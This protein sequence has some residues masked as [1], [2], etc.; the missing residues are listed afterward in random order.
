MALGIGWAGILLL[1]PFV[2]WPRKLG[3]FGCLLL[4]LGL[5]ALMG[6]AFGG[7]WGRGMFSE[8]TAVACAVLLQFL[9][10]ALAVAL[11][12]AGWSVRR[13]FAHPRFLGWL[14]LWLILVW[15]ALTIPCVAFSAL[16]RGEAL[17]GVL[18]IAGLA[19][20]GSFVVTL[21]FLA[22]SAANPLYRERFRQLVLPPEPTS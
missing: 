6:L 22:L 10:F 9:V 3:R 4:G 18:T 5:C 12:L 16:G 21:P 8:I 13:G 11:S 14:L 17:A 19:S 15:L 20:L 1:A 7:H 2:P